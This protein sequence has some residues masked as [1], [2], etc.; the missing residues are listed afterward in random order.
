M[1]DSKFSVLNRLFAV[2]LVHRD[3]IGGRSWRPWTIV[4]LHSIS[5]SG[6]TTAAASTIVVQQMGGCVHRECLS[7]WSLSNL[8][9][10]P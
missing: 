9:S 6:I 2:R 5:S 3:C 7:V 1:P 8:P 10:A 4:E